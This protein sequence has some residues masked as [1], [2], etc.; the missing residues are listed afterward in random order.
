MA[1]KGNI[2]SMRFSDDVVRLIEDQP[3]DT[4]TAKFEA[5]IYHCVQEL[6]SKERDLQVIQDLIDNERW[7]L[8]RIRETAADLE[9]NISRLTNSLQYFSSQTQQVVNS[10]DRLINDCNTN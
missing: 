5:L 6:P 3:G 4:F 2:R 7:R 10:I 8:D 1:N 9:R